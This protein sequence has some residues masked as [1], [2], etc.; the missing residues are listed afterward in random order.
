MGLSTVSTVHR[1]PAAALKDPAL[2]D[3]TRPSGAAHGTSRSVQDAYARDPI[4][5]S[6]LVLDGY[7]LRL[8]VERGQLQLADGLGAHR[9]TRTLSRAERTV[10]RIVI[11]GQSGH[12][13]LEA[14]HWSSAIGLQVLHVDT[15]GRTSA[16]TST[17]GANDARLRRAQALAVDTPI[18]LQITRSLLRAKLEGHAAILT[19]NLQ[20]PEQAAAIHAHAD[21]LSTAPSTVRCR[22]IEA[23]AAIVYFNAWTSRITARFAKADQPAVPAHWQAFNIRRSPLDAGRSPRKAADPIN[24][25]LNYG[26][27]LGEA[28]CILALRAVGLDPGMGILHADKPHRDSL[29]LDLLEPLRPVIERDVLELLNSRHLRKR[30]FHETPEGNCRLLAPLTHELA[31][32]LPAYARACA[33]HAEAIA[34]AL[35]SSSSAPIPLRTP[36]TKSNARAVQKPAG[37]RRS[38]YDPKPELRPVASCR[39]CG[40]LLSEPRQQLCQACWAPERVAL[41]TQ[42]AARGVAERIRRRAAG[43]TDPTQTDEARARRKASL[44]SAKAAEAAWNRAHDGVEANP[45][46]WPDILATLQPIPLSQ[47]QKATGLSL[48]SCSRIRGGYLKPHIRHWPSLAGLSL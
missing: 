14:L 16:L 25:L 4:E 17:A 13:T 36:L 45:D 39:D 43:E 10:R 48:A 2:L 34:H 46:E 30:D 37:R 1:F 38:A 32:R 44:V 8:S 29:A 26:Y 27:A 23:A 41:Q 3:A 42:R 28:E 22:E 24:A 15:Q 20:L 33:P 9:R 35:A 12:L 11:L 31:E 7:G 47:L 5:P 18:G 19:G 40:A 21:T 6:V